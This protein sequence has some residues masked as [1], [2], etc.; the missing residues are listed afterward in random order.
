MLW[1]KPISSGAFHPADDQYDLSLDFDLSGIVDDDGLHEWV[2][3]LQAYFT[4]FVIEILEG[5][6]I[7]I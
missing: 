5:G 4:V 3:G 7:A 6:L 1:A 2:G